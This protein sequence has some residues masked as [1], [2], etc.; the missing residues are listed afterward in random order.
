[1]FRSPCYLCV[2][3]AKTILSTNPHPNSLRLILG[4]FAK[5]REA[6]IRFVMFVSLSVCLSVRPH[7]TT[8]LPLNEFS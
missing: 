3:L 2:P 1:M 6:T 4:A 8:R 7:G 5:L